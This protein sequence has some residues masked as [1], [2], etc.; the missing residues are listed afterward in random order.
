MARPSFAF[1]FAESVVVIDHELVSM[2]FFVPVK[3]ELSKVGKVFSVM[4]MVS[5]SSDVGMK[6]FFLFK[7]SR[8]GFGFVSSFIDTTVP[9]NSRSD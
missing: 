6:A 8:V 4:G 5:F 1:T 7:S 2:S 3:R 9:E